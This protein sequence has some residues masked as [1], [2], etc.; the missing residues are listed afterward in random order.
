[1]LKKVNSELRLSVIS[2]A[3]ERVRIFHGRKVSERFT[4]IFLAEQTSNNL[5]TLCFR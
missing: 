2:Y 5:A 4:E 3:F 1:M